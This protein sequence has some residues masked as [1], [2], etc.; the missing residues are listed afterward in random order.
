MRQ[1]SKHQT[2]FATAAFA[3]GINQAV[4][5]L[6]GAIESLGSF[7][8]FVPPAQKGVNAFFQSVGALLTTMGQLAAQ[9]SAE[10]FAGTILFGQNV[11]KAVAIV[12]AS[13][14]QFAE[15]A[16][17]KGL[18][19]GVL[20]SFSNNLARLLD[21]LGAMVVPAAEN[22]GAALVYGIADG[23]T[24]QLPYL[25]ATLQ[26]A[27]Y[28]MVDTVNSALGIASPSKV[29]EQIGQY[30]GEG[31][32]GGMEAMQPAIAGAGAG[33]GMSAV[34]GTGAAMSGG[35]GGGG[36]GPGSGGLTINIGSG[37]IVLNGVQGGIGEKELRRLAQLLKEE[38]ANERGTR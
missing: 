29:F 27:A 13:F 3:A 35:G 22:I 26:N 32:A 6:K 18:A 37:A 38:I 34:G 16:D 4:A 25:V 10:F 17:L 31:M 28:T 23:I 15:L 21:E 11:S 14:D 36:A 19:A 1:S 30:A 12:K 2:A 33:L 24:A 5:P 9:Y 8:D 7:T 20:T